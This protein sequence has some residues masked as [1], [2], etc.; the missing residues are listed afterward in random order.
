MSPSSIP[1]LEI[2]SSLCLK[3]FQILPPCK[4][5]HFGHTSGCWALLCVLVYKRD[6]AD[7]HIFSVSFSSLK[8]KD[9]IDQT[10]ENVCL[11]HES[12]LYMVG[13][14]IT[15]WH[16]LKINF[17]ATGNCFALG[18]NTKFHRSIA[19]SLQGFNEQIGLYTFLTWLP[20]LFFPPIGKEGEL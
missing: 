18:H 1:H 13:N 4:A 7:C 17:I 20:H 19:V 3:G 14:G 5:L 16:F 8:N 9:N 11:V 10:F 15:Q 2:S 6:G 12:I